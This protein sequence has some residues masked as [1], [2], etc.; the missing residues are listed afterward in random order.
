MFKTKQI[1]DVEVKK[2]RGL[3]IIPPDEIKGYDVIPS[4]YG[5]IFI[6]A[7]KKSG[8]TTVLFNI[9]KKCV[10]KD[11]HVIFFV[12]TF[13]NDQSYAKIKEW[14]DKNDIQHDIYTALKEAKSNHLGTIINRLHT[15]AELEQKM[16][17]E[18]KEEDKKDNPEKEIMKKFNILVEETETEYK[19]KIKKEKKIKKAPKIMFI[20]DDISSELR[21][22][23]DFRKLLKQNRHYKSKTIVSSQWVSDLFPDSRAQQDVWLLFG[24]HS[25]DKLEEIYKACNLPITIENFINIYRFATEE[26]YSFLMIDVRDATFRK[27]FNE[28]ILL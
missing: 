23:A 6:C 20:F 26:P 10:D 4:L 5:N 9:L 17:E 7:K 3:E 14:L 16:K 13:Y 2:I 24:G 25:D 21:N 11:T 22:N 19:F 28:Q 8:K 18:N 15:E 27:N 1:N 12:S